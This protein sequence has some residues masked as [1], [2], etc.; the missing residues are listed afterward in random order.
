MNIK[1]PTLYQ[2]QHRGQRNRYLTL[3]TDEILLTIIFIC[4]YISTIYQHQ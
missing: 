3:D 4:V 2:P 1:T